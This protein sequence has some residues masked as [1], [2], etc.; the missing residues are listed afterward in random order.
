MHSA[1]FTK[2][3]LTEFFRMFACVLGTT[4]ILYA[5]ALVF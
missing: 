1:D 5:Q 2:E 3:S 4:K